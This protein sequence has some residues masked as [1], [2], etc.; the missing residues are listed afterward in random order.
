MCFSLP[1]PASSQMIF[2][3]QALDLTHWLMVLK[4]SFPVI[5]LDEVLK[6]VA[7]NY[8]EGKMLPASEPRQPLS[9]AVSTALP[10]RCEGACP[11]PFQVGVLPAHRPFLLA[12]GLHAQCRY[13]VLGAPTTSSALLALY[14][15][16]S[17]SFDNGCLSVLS[18]HRITC[19]PSSISLKPCHRYRPLFLPLSQLLCPLPALFS[20]L[21]GTQGHLRSQ[22]HPEPLLP[23]PLPRF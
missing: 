5:L 1:L 4:I 16:L 15:H 11:P 17:P 18:G 3:L 23:P 2:K 22:L 8:L 14:A 9:R 20:S 12:P 10:L 21:G 7:R 6:F 13:I 19:S